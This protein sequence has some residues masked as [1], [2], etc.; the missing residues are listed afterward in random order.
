ME[1]A[2]GTSPNFPTVSGA[3]TASFEIVSGQQYLTMSLARFLPPPDVALAIE[4]SGE[5]QTWL[6][7]TVITNSASSLK[8]R[9]SI[10]ASSAPTRFMRLKATR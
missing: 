1:Y 2:L 10:P 9:D 6:R 7:A 3:T 5:L 8:A 4:V